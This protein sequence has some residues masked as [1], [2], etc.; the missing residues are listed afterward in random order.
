M[1]NTDSFIQTLLQCAKH[2]DECASACLEEK[3][4]AHLRD[5]IKY[6]LICADYC[7]TVAKMVQYQSPHLLAAVQLCTSVCATCKEECEKHDHV[8]C[9]TC[10]IVCLE[11]EKLCNEW[12][13]IEAEGHMA[14]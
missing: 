12:L 5:C 2:C 13:T 10:A 11:C 8:H 6:D 7:R 1:L 3:N 14:T 9:K 4:V